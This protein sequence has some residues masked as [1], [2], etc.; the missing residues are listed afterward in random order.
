MLNE[1][2]PFLQEEENTINNLLC[3]TNINIPHIFLSIYKYKYEYNK[4]KK[5]YR[6][7]D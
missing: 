4:P 3:N 7:I 6:Y 2:F 1:L 5:Q